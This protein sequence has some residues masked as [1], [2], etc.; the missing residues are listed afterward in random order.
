MKSTTEECD[1]KLASRHGW[2]VMRNRS[3]VSENYI[4]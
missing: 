3:G 4:C 2:V 1:S